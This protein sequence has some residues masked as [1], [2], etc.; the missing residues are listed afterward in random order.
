[1][2][3]PNQPADGLTTNRFPHGFT[4]VELLVAISIISMLMTLLLPA[5]NA[6]RESSRQTVCAAN[7]RQLGIGIEYN[8]VPNAAQMANVSL[9]QRIGLGRTRQHQSIEVLDLAALSLMPHP[10]ALVR[11][12]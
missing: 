3:V 8:A 5:L 4:L 11:V 2:R 6:A 10:S 1:M 12:P 7:L 9:D